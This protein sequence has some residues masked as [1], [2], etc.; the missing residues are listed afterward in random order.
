M[1][2]LE[3]WRTKSKHLIWTKKGLYKVNQALSSWPRETSCLSTEKQ[4]CHICNKEVE[5]CIEMHLCQN[6]KQGQ[7]LTPKMHQSRQSAYGWFWALQPTRFKIP[8]R[9]WEVQMAHFSKVNLLT[10]PQIGTVS[11]AEVMHLTTEKWISTDAK[12][13]CTL[14]ASRNTVQKCDAQ[15]FCVVGS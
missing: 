3:P 2:A 12:H 10:F 15:S 11:Y 6:M 13:H 5:K 1:G 4:K 8:H 7:S 9:F 14:S